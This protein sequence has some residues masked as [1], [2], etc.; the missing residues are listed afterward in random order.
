M[1]KQNVQLKFK[2]NWKYKVNV[3]AHLQFLEKTIIVSK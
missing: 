3:K 1:K 2:L